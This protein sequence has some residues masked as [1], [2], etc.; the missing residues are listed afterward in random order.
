MY[1]CAPIIIYSF[2]NEFEV[3]VSCQI[4]NWSIKQLRKGV[5]VSFQ[6]RIGTA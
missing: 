2:R 5:A 1:L 3:F 4:V 6:I